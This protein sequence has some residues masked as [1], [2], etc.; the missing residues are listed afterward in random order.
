MAHFTTSPRRYTQTGAATTQ[1]NKPTRLSGPS[2]TLSAPPAQPNKERQ[3]E[4]ER[5]RETD[6]RT[7]RR[8]DTCTHTPRAHRRPLHFLSGDGLLLFCCCYV[9]LAVKVQTLFCSRGSARCSRVVL[10]GIVLN[11]AT[12]ISSTLSRSCDSGAVPPVLLDT[13]PKAPGSTGRRPG[14]KQCHGMRNA[15]KRQRQTQT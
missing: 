10:F 7:N 8:T 11:K 6:G 4:R 9:L 3:G 1:H 12:G 15:H 5:E 14:R 2:G 13:I